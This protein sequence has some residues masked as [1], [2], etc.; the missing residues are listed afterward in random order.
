MLIDK[1]FG[2]AMMGVHL[3]FN[4]VIE[5]NIIRIDTTKLGTTYRHRY[6]MYRPILIRWN[7]IKIEPCMCDKIPKV[8]TFYMHAD[9]Y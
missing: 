6:A 9:G 1:F 5:D 8:K 4:E 2:Q 7:I 3:Q